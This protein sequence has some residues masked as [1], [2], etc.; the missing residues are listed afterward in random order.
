MS[1]VPSHR[2]VVLSVTGSSLHAS[3][4]PTRCG[5][6]TRPPTAIFPAVDRVGK[7]SSSSRQSTGVGELVLIVGKRFV[8]RL[9]CR[10]DAAHNTRRRQFDPPADRGS[11]PE[12]GVELTPIEDENGYIG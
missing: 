5:R 6:P 3:R 4:A 9:G 12:Q 11:H 2:A 10:R 7:R 8:P 1:S